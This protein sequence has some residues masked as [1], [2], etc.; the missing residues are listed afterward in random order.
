MIIRLFGTV[1]SG[2]PEFLMQ[3]VP[4]RLL[5]MI[6]IVPP[7]H[8][9]IRL[10][11][12]RQT[13]SIVWALLPLLTLGIG[14]VFVIGSA[15]ARLAQQKL[16]LAASGYL[17]YFVFVMVLAP[18]VD[19][20]PQDE[21]RNTVAM[22]LW[23]GGMCG[24]GTLHAFLIRKQVFQPKAQVPDSPTDRPRP[25]DPPSTPPGRP[26]PT[27]DPWGAA[28]SSGFTG[29]GRLGPY[30][31]LQKIGEGGQGAVH[32]GRAPDGQQVAVKVLHERFRGRSE[33]LAYLM[34][35]VASAQ[36]VPQ[37]STARI[38]DTGIEGDVAYIVSEF[39]QGNSL[40]WQVR[41]EGPLDVG[42]LIRLAIATSA[43]LNAIHSA[44]IVHRDFKPANV[45]LGPDGPRVI[46]FGIARALDQVSTASAG[47]RGTPAYMSPE[48][49]S[50]RSVGPPS[51]IFSWASSMY[52]GATGRL[53]FGGGTQFQIYESVLHH[54]P[55]LRDLP[56]PLRDPVAA[57]LD[58]DPSKRPTAGRLMVAI[59]R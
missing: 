14:T 52:F 20:P 35:E 38:L 26:S 31:L 28:P 13:L 4:S 58:K 10:S 36:R 41:H 59:A 50:G 6:S 7:S 1:H 46:D 55:D 8:P 44:G 40:E 45:L 29:P 34:R 48:Q 49:V 42:H 5:R 25:T 17:G 37:F 16:W 27:W 19:Y 53:A 57:C 21:L 23:F 43:A 9:P 24:G 47:V 56:P 54:Q 3:N 39:V 18:G 11:S 22:W 30:I 15:A 33:E 12:T 51:D 32:L 2:K